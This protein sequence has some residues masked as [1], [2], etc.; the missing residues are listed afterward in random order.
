V[1]IA[2]DDQLDDEIVVRREIKGQ[3]ERVWQ[4]ALIE[5]SIDIGGNNEVLVCLTTFVTAIVSLSPMMSRS[6]QSLMAA[7]P[8]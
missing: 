1:A 4:T 8:Q 6:A 7:L 5:I 3:D 2:Q